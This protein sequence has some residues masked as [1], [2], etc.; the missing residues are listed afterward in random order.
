MTAFQTQRRAGADSNWLLVYL[1]SPLSQRHSHWR[2]AEVITERQ[3]KREKESREVRCRPG[4]GSIRQHKA[5]ISTKCSLSGSL[6]LP[7]YADSM[8]GR[9]R[10]L[11]HTT[12][13]GRGGVTACV[14]SDEGG[15]ACSRAPFQLCPQV[16]EVK[17]YFHRSTYPSAHT[18]L[19][20][21]LKESQTQTDNPLNTRVHDGN[22]F[23]AVICI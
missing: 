13:N 22:T 2:G 21:W 18:A 16:F 19:Q 15:N 5:A 10:V 23:H 8:Q 12:K 1:T 11:P 9:C 7:P 20:T 14:P 17:G 3:G 6:F 4:K